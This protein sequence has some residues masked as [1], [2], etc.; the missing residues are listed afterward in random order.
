M[1]PLSPRSK[2]ASATPAASSTASVHQ[3]PSHEDAEPTQDTG[4][5]DSA[6]ESPDEEQEGEAPQEAPQE[7]QAAE[8]QPSL[9]LL[10][11]LLVPQS[12]CGIIIGRSGIT[13]RQVAT[14]TETIIK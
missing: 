8:E 7:E 11:K 2:A 13:I 1:A 12:L 14:D 5:S 9:R 6:Q 4:F 10:L 3:P